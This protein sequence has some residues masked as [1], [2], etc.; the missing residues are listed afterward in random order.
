VWVQVK[1]YVAAGA[2][3]P[4]GL[5]VYSMNRPHVGMAANIGNLATPTL[6]FDVV[7]GLITV[8]HDPGGYGEWVDLGLL[9]IAKFTQAAAG[10]TGTT[11]FAFGHAF[12]PN[13]ASAND[14]NA[15]LFITAL[16]IRPV[17]D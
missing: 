6:D 14:A 8:D 2:A 17:L 5:R 7:E 1:S 9:R 12:D 3:V 13:A 10:W 15:R 4:V 16:V 11:H